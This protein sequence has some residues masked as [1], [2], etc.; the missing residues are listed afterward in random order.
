MAVQDVSESAQTPS[1]AATDGGSISDGARGRA[2]LVGSVVAFLFV[3]RSNAQPYVLALLS[4][5]AVIG[6]FALFAGA[7]GI[8]RLST[9]DTGHAFFGALVNSAVD[10]VVVTDQAGRVVYAN[11]AYLKLSEA[12]DADD[13]RPVERVFVGDPGGLRADLSP[14]QGGARGPGARRGTGHQT[15][16]ES[17]RA[18]CVCASGRSLRRGNTR[19]G[20]PGRSAT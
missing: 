19:A 11:A 6:V 15:P 3:G 4:A 20:R 1:T 8:M 16:K 10:G 18:G 14:R 9:K 12:V 13:V 7:A 17:R 2:A 5:L